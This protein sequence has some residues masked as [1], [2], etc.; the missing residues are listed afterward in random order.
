MSINV[1]LVLHTSMKCTLPCSSHACS[2]FL[3]GADP[4]KEPFPAM[5]L[6]LEVVPTPAM[7]PDPIMVPAPAW[8]QLQL[9]L[10]ESNSDSDSGIGNYRYHNSSSGIQP[11]KDRSNG[12]PCTQRIVFSV[13]PGISC[14]PCYNSFEARCHCLDSYFLF[15]FFS[16]VPSD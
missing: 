3:S 2:S 1:T 7:V 16:H 13:A 4:T 6:I 8:N 11:T 12:P 9:R 5:E 10:F 14:L 15:P